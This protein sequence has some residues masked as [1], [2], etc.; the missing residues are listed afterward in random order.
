MF[1]VGDVGS[2]V[3]IFDTDVDIDAVGDVVVV[4]VKM[5]SQ[6]TFCYCSIYFYYPVL[7]RC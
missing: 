6:P 3:V 7:V 2:V 1:V 5:A 4:V